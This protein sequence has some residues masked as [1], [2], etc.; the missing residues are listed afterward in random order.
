MRVGQRP[1]IPRATSLWLAFFEVE[2]ELLTKPERNIMK[3]KE[4]AKLLKELGMNA[5]AETLMK[6]KRG[7]EKLLA[8]VEKYKYATGEDLDDFNAD[9][10]GHGKRLTVVEIKDYKKLPPDHVLESLKQAQADDMFDTFH[11]AYIER[12][13]DPILFGKIKAFKNLFFFI[14]QWGDDVKFEEILGTEY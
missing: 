2:M 1:L 13:K 11:I 3:A 14:D 9:L 7:R 8:A 6:K 4:K 12:V 5:V 10:K